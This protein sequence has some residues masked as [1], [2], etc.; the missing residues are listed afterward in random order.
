MDLPA[1]EYAS[2]GIGPD[3]SSCLQGGRGFSP[4]PGIPGWSFLMNYLQGK[5]APSAVLLGYA[6]EPK[7]K[8]NLIDYQRLADLF[9]FN[10][11]DEVEN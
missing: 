1:N 9:G 2:S 7:R 5:L 3:K 8:N 6:S 10:S 4:V 11:Y